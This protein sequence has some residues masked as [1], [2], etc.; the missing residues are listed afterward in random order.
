MD[1]FVEQI[2]RKTKSAKEYGIIALTVLAALIL[3]AALILFMPP[4]FVLVI[5]I[6]Y[7]AYW[8]IS[9]QNIEFEYSV[10]NGDIDIDQIIARRKRKRIVSV[11][12]GK[13]EAMSP[14]VPAE[15]AN[16]QFDRRVVAAPSEQTATWCFSYRSKK[17]GHTLVVFEPDDRVLA[18][19]KEGL[20]KLVQLELKKKSMS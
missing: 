12:G 19:L 13:I 15:F 10:T 1:T 7:G 4:L 16:R 17:N 14:Y 11:S 6:G 5:A 18:A 9:S 3:T 8:L 2:V 20:P